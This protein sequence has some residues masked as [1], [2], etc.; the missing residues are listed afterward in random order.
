MKKRYCRG[1]YYK[2]G[3]FHDFQYGR[4][5]KWGSNYE[6]FENGGCNYSVAIVELQ[7]GTIVTPMAEDICFLK[8]SKNIWHRFPRM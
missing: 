6:E 7:D 1:K 5:H 3:K 2:D 8:N 4:F